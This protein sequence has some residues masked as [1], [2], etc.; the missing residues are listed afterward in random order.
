VR[1][2]DQILAVARHYR[3]LAYRD[4]E[5][6]KPWLPRPHVAV[7]IAEALEWAAGEDNGLERLLAD[8]I[9]SL[10]GQAERT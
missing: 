7:K 6:A 5:T 10:P 9:S 1:R 2:R 8:L 3:T 4:R